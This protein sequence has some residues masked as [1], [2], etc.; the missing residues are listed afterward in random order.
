MG[1]KQ[2]IFIGGTGRSGTTIL[3]QLLN[4]D[5]TVR[6]LLVELRFHVDPKGLFDLYRNLTVDWD[7]FRGH[8]AVK[9]FRF[10]FDQLN[11]FGSKAYDV[12]DLQNYN[13]KENLLKSEEQFFKALKV[14]KEKRLWTGN[15]PL[16]IRSLNKFS[17]KNSFA[18]KIDLQKKLA[19]FYPDFYATQQVKEEVFFEAANRLFYEIFDLWFKEIDYIIEHTPYNFIN[20][21]YLHKMFPGATLIHSYRHPLDVLS[22]YNNQQWGSKSLEQNMHELIGLY[23]RWFLVD[24]EL[25]DIVYKVKMEDLLTDPNGVLNGLKAHMGAEHLNFDHS[26]FTEKNANVGR[27]KG[28][29]SQL[30]RIEGFKEIEAISHRL[31]YQV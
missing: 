3:S 30:Q 19:R 18:R 5:K 22:S 4:T 10:V 31:G 24:E 17:N 20:F 21:P 14:K 8:D 6:R 29:L 9:N 28:I 27:Y 25:G 23:N 1:Q 11:G 7:M 13:K 26:I 15:S 2:F 16:I 12:I